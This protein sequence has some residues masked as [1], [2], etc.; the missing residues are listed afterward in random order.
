MATIDVDDM[1]GPIWLGR[2]RDLLLKKGLHAH[3]A[4]P[5]SN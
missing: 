1:S 2:E 3:C 4:T 5:M